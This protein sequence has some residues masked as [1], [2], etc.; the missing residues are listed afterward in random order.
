MIIILVSIVIIFTLLYT[1][2]YF[3][4]EFCLTNIYIYVYI[5]YI[6]YILYIYTYVHIHMYVYNIY[7]YHFHFHWRLSEVT[8]S[9]P[10]FLKQLWTIRLP[11]WII[12]TL[13]SLFTTWY[14]YFMAHRRYFAHLSQS[15][16]ETWASWMNWYS[17]SIATNQPVTIQH[18]L[19]CPNEIWYNLQIFGGT[20]E[21]SNTFACIPNL[22]PDILMVPSGKLT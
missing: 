9:W 2:Y 20:P 16:K 18:H 1:L 11:I 10:I 13:P 14:R 5:L 15:Y 12:F 19:L 22:P 7:I 6:I 8:P 4:S 17:P 3:W 21:S